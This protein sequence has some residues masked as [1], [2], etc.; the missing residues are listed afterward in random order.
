NGLYVNSKWELQKE[1]FKG[2]VVN[3]YNDGPLQ[4]GSQL[5][6]F[7]EIESSSPASELKRGEVQE[8]RQITCHL[9]GDYNSLRELSKQLLGVE[10]NDLK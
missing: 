9:Q 6:P 3:S 1:P 2:D 8:Y 4:D 5:G 7:Y 10:L